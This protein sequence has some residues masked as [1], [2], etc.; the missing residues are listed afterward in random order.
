MPSAPVTDYTSD[1]FNPRVL[2]F[3]RALAKVDPQWNWGGRC[4]VDRFIMRLVHTGPN[5]LIMHLPT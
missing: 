2:T 4:F 3:K 1:C 5:L